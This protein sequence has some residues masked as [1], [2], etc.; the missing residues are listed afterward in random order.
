MLLGSCTVERQAGSEP[1]ATAQPVPTPTKAEAETASEAGIAIASADLS[2]LSDARLDAALAAFRISCPSLVK[3]SDSSGLTRA[4]DWDDACAAAAGASSGR[5][6]FTENFRAVRVGD[7]SAFA[8]GYFEPQIAGQRSKAPGYQIPVYGVPT[9]LIDVDL[10]Q[11]SDTLKGKRIRGRVEGN[12]LVPYYDRAAIEAGA[13]AGHAPVIGYAADAVE[14]FFLQVQGSGRL[15]A[16]DGSV[17][18][19]GY[20]GQNGRDYVGIGKL[21]A[22]RGV[23]PRDKR[24]MQ[25]IMEYLRTDPARGAAVMRENPSYIFFQELTGAGPLGALGR[26]VTPR[27]TVAADPKFVPLGAPV[28]LDL[29]ADIADGLWIAQDTG[30]AIKG[31]NRFDTF[32]GAGAE[33]RTIA[34][35]MSGHGSALILLPRAAAERLA[36]RPAQ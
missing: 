15:Q 6:F 20:A 5:T 10:G 34:G 1:P 18:R 21:L 9:D 4:G 24:S 2:R 8:T 31:A 12:S 26:P 28:L 16:P 29:D 3:R 7:G 19:I 23:L 17:I 36:T 11:F 30:G 32:W 22:D 35:G 25:G 14:L 33:A 27:A 13:I